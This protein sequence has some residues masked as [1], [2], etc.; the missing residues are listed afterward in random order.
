MQVD[1]IFVFSS[2]G[3]EADELV[4]FGLI[5]GSG[6]IHPGLGTANRRFFFDDFYLEILWVENESESKSK[7]TSLLNIWERSNFSNN[8]YSPYGLCFK[9]TAS[10]DSLFIKAL[11][12]HADYYPEGKFMEVFT[13]EEKPYLPWFFRL[14][15]MQG[16]KRHLNEPIN[17]DSLGIRKLTKAIFEIQNEELEDRFVD[18]IQSNSV[19]EFSFSSRDYLILEFDNAQKEMVR[20]FE[21]LGIEIRY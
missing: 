21:K 12:F 2:Q 18:M 3:H 11:K 13:N 8:N 9:N 15:A 19:V 5:E 17:R 16:G 1:H 4:N 20:R 7:N 6:R 14:P 10:S